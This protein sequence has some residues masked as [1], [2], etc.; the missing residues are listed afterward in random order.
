M[1]EALTLP[2]A[3]RGRAVWW[4]VLAS[5]VGVALML[6]L[7][8]AWLIQP[9]RAQTERGL[10]LSYTLK[11]VAP[12]ATLAAATFGIVLAIWLW[13]NTRRW[14]GK[15][16]LVAATLLLCA[17][18]WFARQNHFEWMFN[19][20]GASSFARASEASFVA[21]DDMVMTVEVGDERVAYPVRQMAYHHLAHDVVGGTHIVAT[22]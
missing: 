1:N 8:P 14:W 21:L 6:V 7:T 12:W 13:S 18:A 17:S 22:Y 5:L 15:S 9:F 10:G 20:L 19:P 2:H 3:R 11:N 16:A 4:Y